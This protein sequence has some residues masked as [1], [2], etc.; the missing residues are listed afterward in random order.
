MNQVLYH[1]TEAYFEG[2][3]E[4]SSTQLQ[5]THQEYDMQNHNVVS[6]RPSPYILLPLALGS[7]LLHLLVGKVQGGRSEMLNRLLLL[8]VCSG[9]GVGFV[10][11]VDFFGSN[12]D[13][14]YLSLLCLCNWC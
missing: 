1:L 13:L 5:S 12:C 9:L 7:C 3:W 2:M 14:L 4:K 8:Q 6:L 10:V 11:T